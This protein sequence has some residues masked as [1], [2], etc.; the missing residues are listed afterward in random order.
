[1]TEKRKN[2]PAAI[3][4]AL[5][6]TF[7]HW[8]NRPAM[9]AGVA[10]S[11]LGA[12]VADLFMPVFAG[13]MVDAVTLGTSDPA[14]REAAL[15]AFGAIIAL[16][17]VQIALRHIGFQAIVPFTLSIMSDI[18]R[19]AFG[20]V[21]RFSTDWHANTFAGST[22]RRITRGMWA[23]DLLNDTLLISLFPSFV[24]LIGSVVILGLHWPVLG[25]AVAV[26]AVAY[27]TMTAL[28][29]TR[30]IAPAARLGNSWDTRIGGTLADALTCNAVVKSFGNEER[31]DA[32]LARVIGKW[33]TRVRRAWRRGTT[34]STIQLIVLLCVRATVIGG[35]L[36]MWLAGRATPGDV[37]YVL[38]AYFVI[39]AYLRDV[40]QQV[41]H[42]QRAVNDME[43]LVA[44][45]DEA[46]GLVD[47]PDASALSVT[48]GGIAFEDVTFHYR[49]HAMPLYDGLSV[50]I[51]PG[52]RVGL[53]GRSGSGKTT[54]VKLIQRL[55]DVTGGRVAIDGQDVSKAT[56]RSLR[57]QIALVQQEPILFHRSLAE[58][59]AYAK[60]RATQAEIE[61]A[62]H[63]ANAHDFIVGLPRGYNTLVG[64]RG[65]KLSGGERQR[66]ALARAFL[67]DAPILIL[68]E[69]TSSLDSE[70][71][72]LI[73]QAMARLMDGRT[74][75]V[76]AHRLS[77]VRSLDRILVF[78]RGRIVEEGTHDAL[79]RR[80]GGTY[81]MLFERQTGDIGNREE[82]GDLAPDDMRATA[83]E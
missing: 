71:E 67:A 80:S 25:L 41:N 31:E 52:E 62:A 26:G 35:A 17:V 66:V 77:T 24:V 48:G 49:G 19:D 14:A 83:A 15:W 27:L 75:I 68:D 39:H 65:V 28:L 50:A 23:V 53:V 34:A 22:V 12:T 10:V 58:N 82:L 59:I 56:Q 9:L 21:Q 76:I 40:G 57:S 30:Y 47:A 4:A 18:S 11:L 7:R 32:R 44:I 70:S 55:Y 33:R 42:L 6:F 37:A 5:S 38:S 78:D 54:F 8:R 46:I 74:A 13:R 81:R 1:M 73:Q 2:T 79:L 60:P 61:R 3:R 16:G 45:H 63:L 29:A 20:R 64:E 69:A 51:R 72:A 36:V 43:E